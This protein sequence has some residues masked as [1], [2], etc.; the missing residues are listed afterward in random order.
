MF[1]FRIFDLPQELR[2]MIYE[3]ALDARITFRHSC[4]DYIGPAYSLPR[5]EYHEGIFSLQHLKSYCTEVILYR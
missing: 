5:L 3:Y 4:L 2:D 1:S